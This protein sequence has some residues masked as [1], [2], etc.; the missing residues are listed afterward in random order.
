MRRHN[1]D[2]VDAPHVVPCSH[3]SAP[4]VPHRVCGSCG[5]YRGRQVLVV[6]T[7]SAETSS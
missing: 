6:N 4:V 1:H 5:Y 3:C 7:E 2:R